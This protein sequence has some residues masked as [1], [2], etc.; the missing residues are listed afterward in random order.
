M[1]PIRTLFVDDEPA[2]RLTLPMILKQHGF[3]VHA[4][5]TVPQA[6]AAIHCRQFDVLIA[7]LNIGEPGDGFTVVS[8]MRRTQPEC[9]TFILTGFPAFESALRAIRSQVDDYL[10]KPAAPE[11]LVQT[12]QLRLL[13]RKPRK[14]PLLLRVPSLLRANNKLILNRVLKQMKRHPVLGSIPID[15]QDRTTT[16]STVLLEIA[17][18][19]EAGT[20]DN[21]STPIVRSGTNHGDI[22]RAQGYSAAMLVDDTGLLDASSY[23]VV[24]ENLLNIDLSYLVADLKMFNSLLQAH[25][26]ASIQAFTTA[27]DYKSE[28]E[29]ESQKS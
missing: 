24:Q 20:S 21:P 14:A 13:D 2:I 7:D 1:P 27:E 29:V 8:A 9:A 3:E 17:D 12:I 22:R 5:A 23:E 16:L 6:L 18:Q 11:D 25:L 19:I 15:D 10:V 4:A 28:S 26:K